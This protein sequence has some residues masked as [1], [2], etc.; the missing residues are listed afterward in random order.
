MSIMIKINERFK[1]YSVVGESDI[2]RKFSEQFDE[3]FNA[4]E[5]AQNNDE[6]EEFYVSDSDFEKQIESFRTSRTNMVKFCVG[7]TGIGKTTSIR[8]CFGLGVS[9]EASQYTDKK[10]L[11]FPTFLD[12]YQLDDIKRFDLSLRIAAVCTELEERHPELRALLKTV[13]GKKEFYEFIRKH[14]AF[15]LEKIN[16]IDAMDM[17]ENQLIKEKLQCAYNGSP[18]EFQANKLKFY[19]MKNYDKYERLVIILDDIETLPEKYQCEIIAQF[20]KFHEC[21]QNTD[22]PGNHKYHINLLISVRP[23]THRIFR[24][25]RKI[26]T[27]AISEPAIL[28]KES[29]DLDAIFKNRFNYYKNQRINE[30]GN[31]DTW[32]ECYNEVIS[33]NSAF[34]GKYKDMIRNLCFMNIREALASYAKVFANRFWVQK[35]KIKEDYF[36]VVSPEYSF[37]NINVIRALACNE[38]QVYWG[39]SSETII[40][41]IFYTTE[42]NDDYSIICLLVIQYFRK[43]KRGEVYG[44]NS[45]TLE[46]VINEWTNIFGRD[47]VRKFVSALEFLFERKILRKSIYDT[48]D[49]ETLDTK[50]SITDKSKL[51]ISP[52]GNEMY[53]MLGRDSVLLEM[54]RENAWRDFENRNYSELSSNELM[55]ESKQ[56]IIFQDLLDYI[57]YLCEIED[58]VLSVV[59]VLKKNRDYKVAFGNTPVTQLLLTGVRK[60]LDYSGIIHNEDISREY[61]T[62][63]DKVLRIMENF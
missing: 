24:Y 13:N 30:V 52:R 45:E 48:D 8:H 10:E 12:G 21:M 34:E 2:Y 20:L 16:P 57:D 1:R 42:D 14:T 11:V 5:N 15:A 9:K 60:S 31:F 35:N 46:N 55:K 44:L 38:E 53:E 26:E 17:D 49:V 63:K 27:F 29:V 39:D 50:E 47:F 61:T 33:M 36:T 25:N 18:Y 3:L 23:H 6:F 28:K 4:D 32:T 54:L 22:Y 37:N 19:I 62:V 7:Y 56:K 59:K 58:D 51:Y 41:N 40:P 43:K